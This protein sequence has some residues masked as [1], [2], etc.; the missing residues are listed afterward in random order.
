MEIDTS[1][2]NLLKEP[3]KNFYY[4]ETDLLKKHETDFEYPIRK[5]GLDY[6]QSNN[7]FNVFKNKNKY[8]AKVLGSDNNTYQV[9]L[10]VGTKGIKYDCNCPCEFPCKHEYAVLMAV[11]NK[12]YSEIELKETVKEQESDFKSILLKIPAEEIKNYLLS[13]VG[14]DKVVFEMES[15]SNYFRKYYPV[16]K[17]SFYYNNLY[18]ALILKNNY[19]V[20]TQTYLNRIKQ[21]ITGNDF[22]E[23]VKILQAIINAYKDTNQ[24]NFDDNFTD[25]LPNIGMLLRVTYRKSNEHIKNKIKEWI[26][27]LQAQNFY[28]NYY[29]EDIILSVK[30]S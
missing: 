22:F 9:V 1:F 13:E 3:N 19:E 18:N 28:N 15:F 7:V 11:N 23:V 21:Y 20:L 2:Q 17:Y 29:L 26:C 16:Q 25:L 5:R 4:E 12:N 24:L 6:Y 14:M 8:F 10:E 30:D 27:E